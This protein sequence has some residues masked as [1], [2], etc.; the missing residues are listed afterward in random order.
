VIL[1]V[2][3]RR[4]ASREQ[5]GGDSRTWRGWLGIGVV[6]VLSVAYAPTYYRW[7]R[8]NA[9][10]AEDD[11]AMARAGMALRSLTDPRTSIAVDWAGAIPYFS[12]RPAVDLLGKCDP[13]VAR[14]RSRGDFYP[15]HSKWD[16][17]HSIGRLRP[18]L[19]IQT[20]FMTSADREYVQ[21]L[22]YELLPNGIHVLGGA[23][24]LDRDGLARLPLP[25]TAL[26]VAHAGPGR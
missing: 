3:G 2:R 18:E 19:I 7:V 13:H 24:G 4:A 10:H 16:Y 11:A 1:S 21:G 9:Y 23:T 22:G 20:R 25:G 14:T 8:H 26:G 17:G 12:G 5:A 15:G 6:G